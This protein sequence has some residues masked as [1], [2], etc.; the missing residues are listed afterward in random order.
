MPDL[1][2]NAL[3]H[4]HPILV[5]FPIALLVVSWVLDLVSR[6]APSLR[7]SGWVLLVLGTLATIPATITGILAHFPYEGSGAI[8]AIETH[9]R[10]GLL[11]TLIF[12]ALTIWRWWSR[13]RGADIAGSWIYA[14]LTLGGLLVLTLAGANGG[15]LV[16]QLGVGVKGITP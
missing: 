4:P 5:H 8:E 13:R 15:H 7:A 10:L 1:L 6:R 16:Y 3:T 2:N 9:E 12:V 11:T 14:A